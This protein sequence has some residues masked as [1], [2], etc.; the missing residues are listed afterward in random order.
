MREKKAEEYLQHKY[1]K[2]KRKS[3]LYDWLQDTSSLLEENFFLPCRTFW[4]SSLNVPI[5]TKMQRRN[6]L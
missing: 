5:V 1:V 4:G 3:A 2:E 6:A